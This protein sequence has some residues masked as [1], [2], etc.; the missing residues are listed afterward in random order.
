MPGQRARGQL[1]ADGDRLTRSMVTRTVMF[2]AAILILELG[3]I[4]SFSGALHAPGS[5]LIPVAVAPAS[6]PAPATALGSLAAGLRAAHAP[7]ELRPAQPARD[8]IGQLRSGQVFGV[9]TVTPTGLHLL[10]APASGASVA[11]RLEA[12]FSDVAAAAHLPLTV[13]DELPLPAVN[14]EGLVQFYLVLGMVIGGYLLSAVLGLGGGPTPRNL[15]FGLRRLGVLA[16][17][18]VISSVLSLTI[19]DAGLGYQSGHVAA[20]AALVA[21]LVF[22]VG[23]FAMTLIA[24]LGII[25]TWLVIMLF[26]VLG[27]PSAGGAL[28]NVLL[29]APWRQVGPWLPNGAALD[30]LRSIL[31]LG[32]Y[33]LRTPMLVL[34]GY[35]LA[36]LTG[37]L[38]MS[39]RGRQ[40]VSVSA[41][42]SKT[43][44]SGLHA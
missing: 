12:V 4:T 15:R 20:A 32:S 11:T 9:V 23:A 26:V 28:P 2:V 42:P 38:L 13:K 40:L 10:V 41:K 21:L 22:A 8:A 27:N 1:M 6:A 18:A 33:D 19:V 24:A 30:A 39:R 5:G 34:G 37:V 36:G 17:F 3:F 14:P 44:L 29:A 7:V 43:E 31:F 25:G 16:L 35:A